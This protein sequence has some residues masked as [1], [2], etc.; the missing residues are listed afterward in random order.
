MRIA[1]LVLA[2][3]SGCYFS[4]PSAV[5]R[6][7][8][9]RTVAG[10]RIEVETWERIVW[11]S[12][13]SADQRA[14]R[15]ELR[16]GTWQLPRTVYHAK[17]TYNGTLLTQGE[18]YMLTRDGY[19]DTVS[20]VRSR[21]G[22]CKLSLVPSLVALAGGAFAAVAGIAGDK[23]FD[24]SDQAIRYALVGGGVFVGGAL[25]SYPLGGYAC[26]RAGAEGNKVAMD[27]SSESQWYSTDARVVQ[28]VVELA[29]AFNRR[30]GPPASTVAADRETPGVTTA[31]ADVRTPPARTDA[32][33]DIVAIMRANAD[34]SIFVELV[35]AAGLADELAAGTYTVFAPRNHAFESF[36]S[37]AKQEAFANAAATVRRHVA[38]GKLADLAPGD[39][40]SITTLGGVTVDITKHKKGYQ[41][42][43]GKQHEN[44]TVL[45]SG[46]VWPISKVFTN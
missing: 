29:D 10:A 18:L 46:A 4:Y 27:Q 42:A 41:A 5:P 39:K 7:P 30:G 38:N 36:G 17:A 25:L 26:R 8:G 32:T 34:L 45:P 12:C 2:L 40:R 14:N 19:L 22:T 13:G 16:N 15:C 6:V 1:V 35:D 31:S 9:P 28:R 21:K 37:N 20:S 11:S 24:T 43:G 3:L 44:E 33:G 23:L